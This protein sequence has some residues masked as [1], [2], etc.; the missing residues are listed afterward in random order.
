MGAGGSINPLTQPVTLQVGNY[1]VTVPPGSFKQLGQGSKAGSYV[2]SGTIN[3]VSLQVHIV[4]LGSSS[5]AFKA[6]AQPV[7]LT[8]LSNPV[9]VTI[10]IGNN[11][12]TAEAAAK[13]ER[14]S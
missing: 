6:A 9:S 8:G 3:G 2:Y 12:G 11:S 13:F 4:A 14:K 7:D 5:Y 1:S 10:T